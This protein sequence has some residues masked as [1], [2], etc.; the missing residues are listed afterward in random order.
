MTLARLHIKGVSQELREFLKAHGAE[1]KRFGRI[2]RS[3]AGTK[4]WG[5]WAETKDGRRATSISTCSLTEL[6]HCRD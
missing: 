3:D 6:A 1:A 4:T 5:I 2:C